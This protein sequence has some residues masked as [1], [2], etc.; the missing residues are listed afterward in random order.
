[1]SLFNAAKN[2]G[3]APKAK[4]AK[5]SDKAEVSIAG[6]KNLASI[7]VMIAALEAARVTLEDQIKEQMHNT[8]VQDGEEIGKRPANFRGVEDGFEASCELRKRTSRSVLTEEELAMLEQNNIPYETIID[9]KEAFF[10]NPDYAADAA[11]MDKVSKAL[12]K[13]P[14]LPNNFIQYQAEVSRK[15]ASDESLD[16]VFKNGVADALLPVVGTLALKPKTGE[17]DVNA[18]LADVKKILGVK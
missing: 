4:T 2:A 14:G 13:V 9:T 6:L 8:F 10:I 1:M 12:E 17:T 11:L 3:A 16:T 5:K 18:A 7:D 15:V